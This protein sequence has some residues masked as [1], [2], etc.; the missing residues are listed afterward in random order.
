MN[1]LIV[2]A[3][4]NSLS[5]GNVS[6]NILREFYKMN[7]DIG[8]FPI[9]NVDLSAYRADDGFKKYLQNAID[10]R[11]SALSKKSPSLKLWHFNGGDDR[12]SHCQNLFTFYECSDPTDVEIAIAKSQ[13]KVIVSSN[14]AIE[15]FKQKGCDNFVFAPLGFD[16]DFKKTDR[17]Y[18]EG[19]VHFGLMGKFEKRKNTGAIIKAWLE[20]YG[21]NNKY[22]LTCCITNPFFKTE[23]MNE[24]I[25]SLLGGKRYSNINFLPFLKTNKEV[26]ELLN[27]IDIDLTGLSLAEGWN[28]PSFNATCLGKWSIVANHTAHKDWATSDNSIIVDADIPV[29]SHDGVFFV[30]G[31]PFNQ[32]TFHAYSEEALV[33]SF[34]RAEKALAANP[35][36]TKGIDLGQRMTYAVTAKQILKSFE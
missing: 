16:E 21:N 4:L 3:P 24:I 29:D 18:L 34:E 30:T 15:K 7:L 13:N 35:I 12:K 25:K 28:L 36:N 27:A 22:Q 26:N 8:L 20:K 5:F 32:G 6:Y 23:Q 17:K 31:Q 11:Y 19:V 14:D 33:S 1:S 9:G 2:E 10:V